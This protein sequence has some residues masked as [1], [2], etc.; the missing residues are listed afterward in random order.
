[1]GHKH[2]STASGRVGSGRPGLG[3]AQ[4]VLEVSGGISDSERL[5]RCALA[6]G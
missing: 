4:Y 1:M 2:L 3:R 5:R 6:R